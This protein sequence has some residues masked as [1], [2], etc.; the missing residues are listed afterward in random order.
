MPALNELAAKVYTD[1]TTYADVVHFIHIYVIEPHPQSPDVSPYSGRVNEHEYSSGRS[2]PRTYNERL[3]N[4]R[5]IVPFIS[6][7][8]LLLIDDLT[9][10]DINNPLWCTYGPAPNSAYLVRQDGILELVQKWIDVPA[11]EQAINNLAK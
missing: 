7:N 6:G 1:T 5:D 9:P 3:A 11:M 4:A 2:Q 8:Q 10:G